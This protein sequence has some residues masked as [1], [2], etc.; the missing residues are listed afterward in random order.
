MW[1]PECRP[2]GSLGE[3]QSQLVYMIELLH[4]FALSQD[5][6]CQRGVKP[7]CSLSLSSPHLCIYA[8]LTTATQSVLLVYN[9]FLVHL[10][11]CPSH[12]LFITRLQ[13]YLAYVHRRS[14]SCKNYKHL[15]AY[16]LPLCCGSDM[17]PFP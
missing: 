1:P 9:T 10:H 14:L 8:K 17:E 11:L 2:R 7:I 15:S 4:K 5:V 16:H 3:W 12:L 13:K 6:H